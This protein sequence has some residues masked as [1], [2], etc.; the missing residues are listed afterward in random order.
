M[1]V[2]VH[3][4]ICFTS[5]FSSQTFYITRPI[6]Y[7]SI[8]CKSNSTKY[9][10]NFRNFIFIFECSDF[11]NSNRTKLNKGNFPSPVTSS[12]LTS[13][14]KCYLTYKTLHIEAI[15]KCLRLMVSFDKSG[16][17]SSDRCDP[18]N[19]G[20]LYYSYQILHYLSHYSYSIVLIDLKIDLTDYIHIF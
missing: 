19:R 20:R 7:P 17:M 10:I 5:H 2:L 1:H 16:K 18:I 9:C 11:R 6:D 12:V 15:T 14:L 4:C 13:S 3:T 8:I